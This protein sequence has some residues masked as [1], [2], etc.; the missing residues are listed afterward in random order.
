[1]PF[2]AVLLADCSNA[3][4]PMLTASIIQPVLPI[5]HGQRRHQQRACPRGPKRS[6]NHP[7]ILVRLVF[8]FSFSLSLTPEPGASFLQSR[9]QCGSAVDAYTNVPD[10]S[11]K[12]LRDSCQLHHLS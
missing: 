6:T 3:P 4:A 5:G 9:R 8:F 7:L 1:M 12:A 11:P 10:F 2:P